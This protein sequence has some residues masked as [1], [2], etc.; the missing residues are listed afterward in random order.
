LELGHHLDEKQYPVGRWQLKIILKM[1]FYEKSNFLQVDW[2][3]Y[4]KGI[5]VCDPMERQQLGELCGH[6]K[7]Q[8]KILFDW[9]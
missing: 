2:Q 6:C 9:E 7:K 4:F 8:K 5:S 3:V 1:L